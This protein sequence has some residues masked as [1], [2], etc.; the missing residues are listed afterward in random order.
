MAETYSVE[1]VLTAVD[2]GMSST[3]NGLQKAINGLQK[4]SSA[5][6]TVS[7]KSGSM[8]KSMLGANLVSSAI[9]SAVGSIKGSLGEM[10][11]ELNSSK[12][13]WDTFDGN[14]S[15]LG[16]G[17]DQINE[18]KEAMQDYATKTIYSASD[19]AS[20]FSQMAAIGRQDSGQLVEAM[21]GLAAS[22]ENPKQA[23]KSLSQ[24][25]VQALA[26]PKITWQD[27]RVMM[28][29]APAGMSAVAKEMGLSLN[30]LIT[31]IQAGQIKTE[32]F[33][34]AF[35]RAGMSM[36]D[37]ATSYKTID[38][39]LDGL[40]ETLANK[41]KPAFDAL[42]KAGI[43]A[44]EAIMN[45][46]D[47]IDFKKLASGLEEVLNKIDF[48][49]IVEKISS[50]VST[51]VAKIKEFWQGFSNTSAI[52]DFKKALSEVWEAIKK[53][54]SA[55]SGGD[56][57]SFGERI[58]KGLSI[59]SQAIQSFAKVVQSL[60]P[61]QI[62]AIA[63]AFLAFKIA[64]KTTKL[65]TDSLIGLR[66]AVS[67]TKNVFGGM[68]SATRVGTT[69]FGIARGSKAASSALYFM[70]ETSTLAKVAVGGLN[71]FSKVGGWIGPAITAIVGFLGP[72]GLVIAAI[73]AIGAAFVVLWNKS[74]GFRNFFIGLWNG[75]VNV[76]SSAWQKIQS[77]WSGLVEWFSNLWN[78]V[79]ETASNAWNSFV[80][81]TRPVIDAIKSAWN[82]IS[83]FF[84]NLWS[85]IKQI[86]S[87]VWNSFL[88]GARPIVEGLMNVWNALKDFFSALWN[89]IVSVATT[90]WNGIVEVV[91]PIVE[92]IKTAWNSL[93]EFFTNL[94]NSIT[95]GSTTSWNG[96]VEFLTPI[97]ETIKGLWN[98][99][100]EFMSTIW[101][102]IVNVA[103]T[104][105][106]SFQSVIETVWTGIQQF[107]TSAIQVIQNVI[108]TG[109]QIVQ[110]VWNAVWTVF[111]TIVQTAWT[112][113][114][115]II[116]TVLNVIA[117]IINTVTSIIKGDWSV[118]WE[119]IKGVAQTVWE[120]IKSVISTVINAISS[121]ISTVLGTIK[122]TVTTIWNGI[123]DFI[124][125]TINNI[126]G[127]VINV[128]NS[129]KDGFL[130]VLDSLK[131][132]VSNAIEAVKSFFNRLWNIDLSG[133]G[134][135]IMEGFLGGLKSM[136]GAVTDFVGG[137]ASWIAAHKGP[138]SYDRRLLIP[139]GQAIMGSFNT[140]LMDGFEDVKSNVSGM[141]DG[142][143]SMFDDAGSRV[144]A[145]SNALQ[146]DFSNN[147][148]GTLSATY[149]VNQTKEPA[150]INLALGSN[151]FRAFVSDISNIQ[152]KE[153]R[154]RLKAQSL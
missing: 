68:Q 66:S 15:K 55:L 2:K 6:D 146:G 75:I 137:I 70:S 76:A 130:N 98:S 124:S 69:L 35:K 16:W 1:A 138:I 128:A 133:A 100:S 123:K 10:V 56:M 126:K 41:L 47:K 42:S 60:S 103:T 97:V 87:D 131:N 134:R 22:A 107:I 119:N 74:E 141:A 140:A 33:A 4:T 144:S 121:I 32:D 40:K 19:M 101:S 95:E 79:K 12:K 59:A 91:T 84:S 142:I 46:L 48:N 54:A 5:F 147:V 153:E 78:S 51:S 65:A 11:G 29:Q 52:A 102:G 145:M 49:A 77:A 44:L 63:S 154:I 14:L 20:T 43:K 71:I 62:R 67:T 118:A 64:Q 106:N 152:S 112:V 151:D 23:M 109:M 85:G 88:E 113:I 26:K 21:G 96:F 83:E 9:G 139:A 125:N 37:M 105:W 39:A 129:L 90:V 57:A 143:R 104:A 136:W 89:G 99:F 53:V 94:W 50:F 30:E 24:Q 25:M 7:Q 127:I 135:A 17:K 150:I 73:V 18:A 28:E 61:E 82:T 81:K 31:K 86:A 116:S 45:Q 80:E 93:V 117:G 120:G 115:T 122:N 13:A 110:E 38:Q 111:T 148:S 27:F 108:T 8:F 149:E 36:Q 92:A 132:G 114:S 58:G 72:V 34:E 3:L